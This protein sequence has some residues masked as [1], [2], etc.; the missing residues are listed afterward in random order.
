MLFC[1]LDINCHTG[2]MLCSPSI[3]RECNLKTKEILKKIE[4]RF[5]STVTVIHDLFDKS[6]QVLI[7]I[8]NVL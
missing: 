7:L 2:V 6:N 4:S 3:Y 8:K 1:Y 5:N